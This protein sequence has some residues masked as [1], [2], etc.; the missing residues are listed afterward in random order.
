MGFNITG[1]L[2]KK[3]FDNE[4]EIETFLE[5]KIEFSKDVDFDEA[6]SSFRDKNTVDILQTENGG[7]IITGLGELY[8]LVKTEN[9]VIQFMVSDVSDTYYF[10]KYSAGQLVRKYI[11]SQGETIENIGEGFI[12]ENED[13]I[14]NIWAFADEYLKNDF[15]KNMFHLKFKRYIC[16]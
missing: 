12:N 6:T 4:Q 13:L 10:E 7:F 5:K 8:N 14:E 9:E 15:T 2:V 16:K 11:S 1:I 3:K